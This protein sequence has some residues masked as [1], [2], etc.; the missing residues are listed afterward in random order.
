[1]NDRQQS[2]SQRMLAQVLEA[3]DKA[4]LV[5]SLAVRQNKGPHQ[6]VVE[7]L[8]HRQQQAHLKNI[9]DKL[10][11]ADIAWIIENVSPDDRQLIWLLQAPDNGGEI[12]LE[13][14]DAIIQLL[15]ESS[16][17]TLLRRVLG[18]LDVDDLACL[19]DWLP[20][21]LLRSRQAE[22]NR[23]DQAWVRQSM[24]YPDDSVG[25][26]MIRDMLTLQET[27]SLQQV[28]DN[29]RGRKNLPEQNDKF[30]VINRHGLL[31]GVLPWQ[32]LVLND[33]EKQVSDVMAREVVKFS[34][35]D[36]AAEAARAFERYNLVSAPVVN[37]RGRLLGRLTVESI[38]DFVRDDISED[39]LN[40]AGLEREEDLFAPVWN[41]A[42][43]RWT[44]L[45]LSLLTAFLASRVIGQFEE[46]IARFVALAAL[47][48]IVAAIGGNTGNQ[49]TTLVVRGLA[50]GQIN[51]SNRRQLV[52]KEMTMSLL[53]GVVWGGIVGL[54]TL[55]VY[56]NW[57]LA[58][59]IAL[60]MQLT[61]LLAAIL[62]LAIPLTLQSL[63]RDPALGSGVL[64]TALTDSLGFFIF[65][66]LAS[67]LIIH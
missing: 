40:A 9:L 60:A 47:M 65:L 63:N 43:N 11:P 12:L 21:D 36:S 31:V 22:L 55:V 50:L 4:R 23:D 35:D 27:L 67:V 42:R 66:G 54:F 13:L 16:D 5:E 7:N 6:T 30:P 26:L 15:V 48:P 41:S 18:Q 33:P 1:M 25:E 49:T 24:G 34:P 14:P 57:Q 3:L 44:W 39:A 53:N 37:N 61:L 10:H 56:A 64:V 52:R 19:G 45:A 58:G 17:K 20:D 2:H 51:A 46:T 28:L 29:L 59:V 32:A 8:V 62:G 38:M